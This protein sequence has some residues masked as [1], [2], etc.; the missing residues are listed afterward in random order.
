[1]HIL[2][3]AYQLQKHTSYNNNNDGDKK[4]CQLKQVFMGMYMNSWIFLLP[5]Y[6]SGR[7]PVPRKYQI[8]YIFCDKK[9]STNLTKKIIISKCNKNLNEH[10]Y[11]QCSFKI[12]HMSNRGWFLKSSNVMLPTILSTFFWNSR[13]ICH[14]KKYYDY[15]YQK[16]TNV[17]EIVEQITHG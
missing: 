7:L 17:S 13:I 10:V 3:L 16:C 6:N 12:L 5:R 1:M 11:A 9:K 8:K 15:Q 2:N 4:V 14:I